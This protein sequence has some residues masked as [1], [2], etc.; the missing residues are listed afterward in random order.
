M[1]SCQTEVTKQ[2]IYLFR[3]QLLPGSCDCAVTKVTTVATIGQTHLCIVV[4]RTSLNWEL[5]RKTTANTTGL[6]ENLRR[7][8][9]RPIGFVA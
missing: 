4:S 2:Y 5:R 7:V 9:T 8:E 1:Y 3:V 6:R